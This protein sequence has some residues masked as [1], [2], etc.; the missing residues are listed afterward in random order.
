[1]SLFIGRLGSRGLTIMHSR[2]QSELEHL[3]RG[4]TN[5]NFSSDFG[6][7]AVLPVTE[8]RCSTYEDLLAAIGGLILFGEALWYDHAR[9]LLSR[10]KR[11][12][13][14]NMERDS[15]TPERVLLTLL[16]VN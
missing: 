15:N 10:L 3:R 4:S 14:A 5:A 11:F 8:A 1:M 12:V 16:H 9:R 2:P 7:G 13:L 6:A